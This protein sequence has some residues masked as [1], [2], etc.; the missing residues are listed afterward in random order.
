MATLAF[1]WSSG[2]TV[3]LSKKQQGTCINYQEPRPLCWSLLERC[4][5][6]ACFPSTNPA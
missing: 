5:S 1:G 3:P 2:F 4:S 6:E